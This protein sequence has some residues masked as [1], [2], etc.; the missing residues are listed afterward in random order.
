MST[1][2]ETIIKNKIDLVKD[3]VNKNQL[4]NAEDILNDLLQEDPASIESLVWLAL[5]KKMQGDFKSAIILTTK[6]SNIVP[7]N[8][9]I[10]NLIGLYSMDFGDDAKALDIFKKSPNKGKR[11][12]ANVLKEKRIA[13]EIKINFVLAFISGPTIAIAVAP[14]IDKPD[15]SKILSFISN[16]NT[17]PVIK[18]ITKENIIKNKTQ[19]A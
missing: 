17:F 8:T 14:Q 15:A 12:I 2:T 4:N 13:K 10:L 19:M 3:Y 18:D 7:N 9:D 11:I 1:P 5:V 6:A 16:P